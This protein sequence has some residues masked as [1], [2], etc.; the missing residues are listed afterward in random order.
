MVH[1]RAV[2][3]RPAASRGRRRPALTG[4][5]LCL[6]LPVLAHAET[7][8][9][10]KGETLY[11]ISRKFDVPVAVL[12]AFND[13]ADP[14]QLKVGAQIR[15]PE[16]YSVQKGD[17]LYGIARAHQLPLND[18]MRLNGM[19]EGE[20]LRAGQVLYVPG[21]PTARVSSPRSPRGRRWCR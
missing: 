5:L 13:I 1:L 11:R 7:H 10:Q 17:T 3:E 19:R 4:L 20:T 9:V 15:L 2:G 14:S 8:T 21:K 12:Q 6:L 16:R 18:L